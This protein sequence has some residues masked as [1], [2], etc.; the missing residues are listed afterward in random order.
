MEISSHPVWDSPFSEHGLYMESKGK[1]D[2]EEKVGDRT[3]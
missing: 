2:E 3:E 1:R